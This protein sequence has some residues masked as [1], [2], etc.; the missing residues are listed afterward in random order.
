MSTKTSLFSATRS[1]QTAADARS[2]SSPA[3]TR[4]TQVA[5]ERLRCFLQERRVER[6][7]GALDVGARDQTGD[8]DRRGRDQPEVDALVGQRPEHARRHTGVR[9][10]AG[11]DQRD[12]ADAV[13]LLDLDR[14]ERLLS[15]RQRAAGAGTSRAGRENETRRS[16]RDVLEDR[17]DVDVLG[18]DGV[19]DR[20][21]GP[22]PVG[23]AASARR[24][25]RPRECVTAGDDRL[26]HA[27]GVVR[28]RCR[29]RPRT[30]SARGCGRL[31]LRASSTAR[32][33]ST[34]APG[35]RHLEHL[36]VRDDVELAAPPGRRGDRR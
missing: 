31:V 8:L 21:R 36:L 3:R 23:D 22:G 25:P 6:P 16:V 5:I 13:D 28:S 9:A 4:T 20:R 7:D 30:S 32:S 26:L 29:A 33:I 27:V 17:V 35:S 1:T 15:Q 19:E 14:A 34:F 18:G 10:H 2:R 24:R 11:S 12:L